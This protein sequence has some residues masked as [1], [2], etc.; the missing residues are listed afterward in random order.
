MRHRIYA[1]QSLDTYATERLSRLGD[2]VVSSDPVELVMLREIVDATAL[3]VRGQA[4]ITAAV[5]A[6]APGLKVIG[7]TGVGYDTVDIAAATARGIP[8]VFT[9]G[10][11]ARAV[12]EAA[13]AYMLALCKM[14]PYWDVQLKSGNW[15]SRYAVQGRDLDCRTLGIVGFGRIGQMLAEMAQPF[16]MRIVAHDPIGDVQRAAALGVELLPLDALMRSADFISLHCPP[17][18]DTLG[19][20][21][22]ERLSL[23]KPGTYLINLARGVVIESFDVLHEMLQNGQLGGVALDVFDPAPPDV[24]HP[25]FSHPGCI[26]SPHS[27]ATTRGAMTRIFKSMADDM[28]AILEGR[29]PNFVVNPE[30]LT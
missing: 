15:K 13:M 6:A 9:P 20:I 4:P 14:I 2:F 11:G 17:A 26:G 8:V 23:V 10:V 30:V 29:R 7:R 28:A 3:V 19:L 12:A 25:L 18:P 16:N 5:I 1:T 21:N 22:R 27:M 24:S